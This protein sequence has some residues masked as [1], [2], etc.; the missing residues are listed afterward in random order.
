MSLYEDVEP[1]LEE[2]VDF[3]E[4]DFWVTRDKRMLPISGMSDDHILNV[5]NMFA[6]YIQ[7]PTMLVDRAIKLKKG[8]V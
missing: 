3:S 2:C 7:L 4:D 5:Y 6:G 8:L 1:V